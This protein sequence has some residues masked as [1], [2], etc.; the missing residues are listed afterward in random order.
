MPSWK[1][2]WNNSERAKSW[3]TSARHGVETLGSLIRS[4]TYTQPAKRS[5]KTIR[6]TPV[7]RDLDHFAPGAG[8]GSARS[9]PKE[10]VG[11]RTACALALDLRLGPGDLRLKDLDPLLQ[12]GHT[13]Q[14]QVLTDG[15]DQALAATDTDFSRF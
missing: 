8:A 10:G 12:L 4:S 11:R 7:P 14:F 3:M 13:E 15:F 6:A 9:G 5:R 1:V 2:R